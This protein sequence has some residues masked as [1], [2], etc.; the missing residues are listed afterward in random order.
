MSRW[1]RA[2]SAAGTT[3]HTL[4]VLNVHLANAIKR[5]SYVR[6]HFGE[7]FFRLIRDIRIVVPLVHIAILPER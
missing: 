6:W 1:E 5:L 7:G 2:T 3:F 4:S